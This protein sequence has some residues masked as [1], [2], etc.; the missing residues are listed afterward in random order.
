M[1]CDLAWRFRPAEDAR[2]RTTYYKDYR[3]FTLTRD[4]NTCS[5][6]VESVGEYH[7]GTGAKRSG[8]RKGKKGKKG[9]REAPVTTDFVPAKTQMR[10]DENGANADTTTAADQVFVVAAE[11]TSSTWAVVRG[12]RA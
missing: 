10:I 8:R 7:S 4:V 2:G 6:V 12:A 1:A 5:L 3:R 9:K 11:G